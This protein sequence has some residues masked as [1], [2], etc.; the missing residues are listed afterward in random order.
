VPACRRMRIAQ[1]NL[2]PTDGVAQH[3]QTSAAQ[4]LIQLCAFQRSRGRGGMIVRQQV[5]KTTVT[6]FTY[7][8]IPESVP[9]VRRLVRA[10]L[11]HSPRVDDVELIAAE[12]VTNAISHTP[13][14]HEGGAFTIT[15]KQGPGRARLEVADLGTVPWHPAHPNRDGMA[16]HG[17]GLE[18]VAAL[19]DDVGYGVS[20][21][22]NRLSWAALS[23]LHR[24]RRVVCAS[25]TTRLRSGGRDISRSP[26][27]D[28]SLIRMAPANVS[29]GHDRARPAVHRAGRPVPAT[30][31]TACGADELRRHSADRAV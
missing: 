23:W 11:V 9:V 6:S 5:A 8:G 17:R 29:N 4:F 28:V 21:G 16:E 12:L 24:P 2:S 3:G 7:P 10:I 31:L 19:A 18:I 20:D 22:H 14:G 1:L 27:A 13:S 25:R 26:G 30:R 15:V